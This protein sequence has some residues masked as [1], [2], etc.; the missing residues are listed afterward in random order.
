MLLTFYLLFIGLHVSEGCAL[1]R[2]GG[3]QLSITAQKRGS[4]L[5]PC[6][7]TDLNTK[8][9]ALIWRKYNSHT[10]Q[11]E[12]MSLK[13]DQYRDR[14]QLFNGHSPGNLSLLISHL[15]EEDGGDYRC[16]VKDSHISIRL[17]LKGC[18]LVN[19][20]QALDIT[21]HIGG[22][23]LLP[24]YCTD[25]QTT[26]EEFRWTK[27]NTKTGKRENI[28]SQSGQYRNRVQLVNG[29]SPGNLSLLISHLTEEDGGVYM[30]GV[31]GAHL[32][33]RLTLKEGPP[34]ITPTRAVV[35]VQT[36]PATSTT[37]STQ[38]PDEGPPTTTPTRTVVSVQ[39]IPATSA[40]HSSQKPDEG[41]PTTTPTRTVVSVQTRPAT[42]T[43]HS[44]QKSD[45]GPPTTTPTRTVVSVQ[46]RPATSTTHSTQ[47]PDEGP[48]TTTPTRTV[49][50][51]QTRP[52]TSTTHSSQKPDEGPPTTTP[53]R[54]VVSVQTIPATSATHSSQKPDEG[55]PTT[56]PTRAVVSVQ[57]RPATSTTHSSQ[58]PDEG[59]PTTTPTRTVVSVQTRPATSTTHSTQKPDEAPPTTT[60]RAVVN[61]QT[62]PATST[63]H[64]SQKPDEGPPTTTPTRAV[65]SVQTRPATST[66]HSTQKPDEGPPTTIPTRAVVSVQTRPATST[67][68]SSQKPDDYSMHFS[69]FISVLLLLLGL[70]GLI[71]WRYRGRRRGQT[72]SQ[73]K[74]RIKR[75]QKTQDE[76]TYSTVVHSNTTT[77]TT[78]VIDIEEKAEYATIRV[79]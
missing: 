21:A 17:T 74:R 43:T 22:S 56:T 70:G 65:V 24:C 36:R 53:T 3:P 42:S 45:E 16:E 7:C 71:Y 46:T 5:L 59:P 72:E 35:S 73:E 48:P 14:V 69:I 32:M 49:V 37:H 40:T 19:R 25:L 6:Y 29:H 55:P 26:P 60:T 12:D 64:S 1:E 4:A 10:N 8:P 79:N 28:S 50:N 62:R 76:V 39:T 77:T 9:E 67:T 23:V 66:T 13:G 34:T 63:T 44:T 52:A 20:E 78:T 51:V 54:T 27:D 47:K 18:N 57:T 11:W 38:K 2:S 41:P 75:G 61:V 68:H 31:K 58:K 15:T 33:I 30:C